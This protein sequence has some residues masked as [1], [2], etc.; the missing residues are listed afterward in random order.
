MTILPGERVLSTP[1]L[2]RHCAGG[3]VAATLA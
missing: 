3:S 2:L 1:G